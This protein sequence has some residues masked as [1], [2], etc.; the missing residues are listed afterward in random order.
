MPFS[1]LSDPADLARAHAVWEAVWND[2]KISIP[3]AE[4]ERERTRLAYLVAGCAPMALDEEDLKD[5]V[6]LQYRHRR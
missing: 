6:I 3:E 1:S 5:N 2:V 4:Q